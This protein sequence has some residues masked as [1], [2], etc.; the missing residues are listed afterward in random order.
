MIKFL[1]L[2]GVFSYI[3]SS[4]CTRNCSLLWQDLFLIEMFIEANKMRFCAIMDRF[5]ICLCAPYTILKNSSHLTALKTDAS[6]K[7]KA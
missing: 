2:F 6:D 3:C 5:L 4:N 1:D 7:Q